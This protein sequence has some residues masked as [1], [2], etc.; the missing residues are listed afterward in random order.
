MAEAG[1]E[2]GAPNQTDQVT[3]EQPTAE[4]TTGAPRKPYWVA[5]DGTVNFNRDEAVAANE[6][7]K[8]KTKR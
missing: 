1:N 6:V 5:Q 3:N 4:V 2:G 8:D 7:G